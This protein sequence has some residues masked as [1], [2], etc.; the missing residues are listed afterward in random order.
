MIVL[1]ILTVISFIVGLFFIGLPWFVSLTIWQSVFLVLLVACSCFVGG[2]GA[3]AVVYRWKRNVWSKQ[4]ARFSWYNRMGL[5][6]SACMLEP[7]HAGMYW[8]KIHGMFFTK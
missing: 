4:Y 1:V 6:E 8:M 7:K 2:Y 5:L 3:S